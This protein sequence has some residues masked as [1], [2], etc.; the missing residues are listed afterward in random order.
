MVG[1]I[2]PGHCRRPDIVAD[3]A[4]A[5]LT[6]SSRQCTGNFFIDEEVLRQEGIADFARYAVDPEGKLMTDLFVAG[7]GE[8]Q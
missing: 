2:Q 8:G 4:H 7:H 6:R 3:A 1:G 5:V